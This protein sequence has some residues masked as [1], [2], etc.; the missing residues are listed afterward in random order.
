MKKVLLVVVAVGFMIA[1]GKSYNH[2]SVSFFQ[3]SYL[4]NTGNLGI[5]TFYTPA[6]DSDCQV[7]TYIEDIALTTGVTTTLRWTDNK[8]AIVQVSSTHYGYPQVVHALGGTN[9]TVQVTDGTGTQQY[10]LYVSG[11][12]Q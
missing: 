9:L 6:T 12:C 5:T 4:S 7:S 8:G 10:N 2:K 3:E 11:M 1:V